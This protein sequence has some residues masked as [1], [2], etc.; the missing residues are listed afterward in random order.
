MVTGATGRFHVGDFAGGNALAERI[1]LEA[2]PLIDSQPLVA[3]MV[4]RLGTSR[5]ALRGDVGASLPLWL[6]VVECFDAAGERGGACT[7]RANAGFAWL[8]LGMNDEAEKALRRALADG[9]V[10]DMRIAA[11]AA[12]HNLGLVLARRGAT[13]EAI[14]EETM[15]LEV[16]RARGDQ[17]MAGACRVYLSIILQRAGELERAEAEARQAAADFEGY[18]PSRP[19]ALAQ[20]AR[21]LLERGR[22]EEA[23]T[24]AESAMSMLRA[25]PVDDGESTVRLMFAEALRATGREAEGALAL[26]EAHERLRARAALISDASLRERFL[27]DVPENARTI[28]L[29]RQLLV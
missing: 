7:A 19:H 15:A 12:R 4:H 18:P 23:L 9:L 1:G 28:A 22:A 11:A 25:G 8:T 10:L 17:R 21:V 20:L 6:R 26:R 14:Q 2:G 16:F 29:A 27:S 24:H 13:E 5:A 3:A